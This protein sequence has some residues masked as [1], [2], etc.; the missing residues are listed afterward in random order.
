MSEPSPSTRSPQKT[1]AFSQAHP[2]LEKP[3]F[4]VPN[5]PIYETRLIRVGLFRCHPDH[6]RFEDSGAIEDNLLVF[7]RT[8]VYIQHEDGEKIVTGPNVVMFYNQGQVYRRYRISER[9]DQ[10]EWFAFDSNLVVDA[11]RPYDAKV[12]AHPEHPFRLTHGL[13]DPT[14]YLLQRRVVEHLLSE[15]GP[16]E[17]FIEES[18]LWILERT[19]EKAYRKPR[20]T[21][22]A[23]SI[24]RERVRALQAALTTRFQERLNLEKLA[25]EFDYSPYYLCRIFRQYT[26]ST[27]HQYLTQVR[28]RTALEWILDNECNL[29]ELAFRLGFSSHSHFTL[30]FRKA[31]GVPPTQIQEVHAH[32]L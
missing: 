10:C 29:T 14:C 27:I 32:N 21:G 1:T 18:L 13:S 12:E 24:Q 5:I 16:D 2:E 7:P 15:G 23:Q 30:A 17:L 20:Q 28:L 31:F 11:L 3:Y 6:P 19:I 25:A 26:G 22:Q 4:E 9:G 8:S